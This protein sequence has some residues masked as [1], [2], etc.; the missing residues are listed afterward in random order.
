M[1][2]LLTLVMANSPT[3]FAGRLIFYKI[4]IMNSHDASF[5]SH[6]ANIKPKAMIIENKLKV[7]FVATRRIKAD[8]ELSWE[9][10][11]DGK[12]EEPWTRCFCS[13]KR[14]KVYLNNPIKFFKIF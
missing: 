7:G 10:D 13:S 3:T 5:F 6:L 8:E 14:K 11:Y 2:A 12:G 4:K 9:Y 1:H